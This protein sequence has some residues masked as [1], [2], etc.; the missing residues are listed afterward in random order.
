MYDRIIIRGFFP[1]DSATHSR[2]IPSPVQP[3]GFDYANK[4]IEGEEENE[5]DRSTHD[6]DATMIGF[7]QRFKRQD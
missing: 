1:T 7:V 2:E 4:Q 5:D 6:M 3:I